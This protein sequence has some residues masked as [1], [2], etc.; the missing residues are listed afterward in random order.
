MPRRPERFAGPVPPEAAAIPSLFG[1]LTTF[2]SGARGCIGWRF[3]LAEY[4]SLGTENPRSRLTQ[5]RFLQDEV[6]FVHVDPKFR[7]RYRSSDYYW[8]APSVRFH[9]IVSVATLMLVTA[10]S[11]RLRTSRATI[12]RSRCRSRSQCI[13]MVV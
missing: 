2:M 1:N 5:K 12:P 6:H 8:V 7:V 10:G 4:V 3:A 11:C 9:P 13:K